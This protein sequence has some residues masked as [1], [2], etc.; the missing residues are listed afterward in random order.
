[1]LKIGEFASLSSISIHMLRHYDKIGMLSPQYVDANNGY[2][3]YDISQLVQANQ[4][5]ALKNMGFGLED[6]TEALMASKDKIEML[7]KHKLE[8]KIEEAKIIEQQ[9]KALQKTIHFE[10]SSEEHALSIIV[11]KMPQMDVVSFRDYISQYNEEGRLWNTLVQESQKYKI[12]ISSNS[13]ALAIQHMISNHENKID[14]EVLLSTEKKEKDIG[15]IQAKTIPQREVASIIFKGSYSKIGEINLFIAKW[16]EENNYEICDK[17]FSIYHKSP[18]E[19]EAE[20]EFITEL[21]F[22]ISKK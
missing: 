21:C 16:L 17:A 8:S 22:P 15:L 12:S 19:C 7:L 6:I 11:K 10:E 3:Y 9:I 5:V 14:V 13:V 1:M 2:R 18:R 20:E 4:I